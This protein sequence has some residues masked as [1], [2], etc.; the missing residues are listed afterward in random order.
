MDKTYLSKERHDEL[1]EELKRLKTTGRQEIAKRLKHAKELGDLSE[2][3][4][5]QEAR[6][7]QEFLERRINQLEEVLRNSEIIKK[8]KNSDTVD[9]GSQVTVKQGRK[10]R[11]F[12]IV[13]S[14]ET[15]P[16]EGLIS[17]ESPTGIALLGK[18]VGDQAH[19]TT[20]KGTVSYTITK[21]T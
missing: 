7:D 11:K 19:V 4:E 10:K 1:V 6:N 9:V 8:S 5:Y 15:N 18:K 13:G 14:S 17:N 20:P 3:S 21:I 16:E 12:T 2:N